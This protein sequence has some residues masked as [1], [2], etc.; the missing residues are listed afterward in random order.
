MG[1]KHSCPNRVPLIHPK[2]YNEIL[3][4]KIIDLEKKIVE[5]KNIICDNRKYILS[6]ER[7]N[8]DLRDEIDELQN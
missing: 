8:D 3:E 5:L 7:A 4:K 1:S 6:L 2:D